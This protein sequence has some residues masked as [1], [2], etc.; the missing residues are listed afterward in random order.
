[1]PKREYEP[2]KAVPGFKATQGMLV[3][4]KSTKDVPFGTS[5][6]KVDCHVTA[7]TKSNGGRGFRGQMR[8]I[9][10]FHVTFE[11]KDDGKLGQYNY[12][13]SNGSIGAPKWGG[14]GIELTDGVM[15]SLAAISAQKAKAM[16]KL[17]SK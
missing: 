15:A 16:T 2:G 7:T 11:T 13:C 9:N 6:V 1:M 5:K 4:M 8:Y 3:G 10:H 14:N 17:V 12:S